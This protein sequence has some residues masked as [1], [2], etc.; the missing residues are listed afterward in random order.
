MRAAPATAFTEARL[1]RPVYCVIEHEHRDRAVAESVRAGRFRYFGQTLDLG[2]EPDWTGA[3]LPAD[4]EWRIA[5]SKFYDGLDLAH[6]FAESRDRSFLQTWERLVAS[7]IRQ[8][9]VGWDSSDVAARRVQN[10]IYAW[11]RFAAAPGFP[12]LAPGLADEI[13]RSVT[14]QAVFVR[15]N[16][17]P[18]RNHRTFELYTLFLVALALPA[19]DPGGARLAEAIRLLHENLLA[20]VL[21]D[22]V[23][24][25]C[26]THYHLLALRSFLGASENARRFA[27][28]LPD[29]FDARLERACAF[30]LHCHRPDGEIPALSDSDAGS[31]R[32]VL[33]LAG[34]LLER[35]EL[36]YAA[37]A[38]AQG[39][40]PCHRYASFPAGG[41]FFQRS[42]WGTDGAA[43]DD[44]RF[45]VFDCGPLGDGG[46]GHY[47]LLAIEA[48][49][50][51]R[52]L[53]VDPGRY[54]YAESSPNWRHWFKSTA[55][56]NTV[57]V[58]GLDQ[59]PYRRRKPKGPIARG[60]FRGR[61]TAPGLDLLC[62]EATSPCYDAVHT[63][64]VAFV[65]DEYWL[66]EDR[67]RAE[68]PHRYDL[69]FH[70]A[71]EAYSATEIARDGRTTTVRA[72][73]LAL[74]VVSSDVAVP[75]LEEGWF[76]PEYGRK[77]PAPVVSVAV[78]GATSA[79]FLTLVAPVEASGRVP[80]LRVRTAEEAAVV[81]VAGFGH[82]DVVTWTRTRAAWW[83]TSEAGDPLA[84]RLCG[85]DE[86]WVA[87]D[88]D[89]SFRRG[90]EVP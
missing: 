46:H 88:R 18:A 81:E 8:V 15:S 27:L 43:F 57:C 22:G 62:G 20:D 41:Y 31:Y 24:C 12:G 37:T 47:D 64:R 42:G 21:P 28:R 52:P 35:P 80:S 16:L 87:W 44:E 45:L 34:S 60:R 13:V 68:E 10:W 51:G 11:Q 71:A 7:W 67:L 89:G 59:T 33:V 40:P 25:E 30:A 54:T 79:T 50:G 65:S 74:V 4:E 86:D 48:A 19:T 85:A 61:L 56:H 23:H 32:E 55:A 58:D 1:P 83:R 6:A 84:F 70:L 38:G 9:P 63:R 82:R 39:I 29:G 72:P 90:S 17:T 5:W 76:A 3:A 49:A 14:E 36:L 69:R 78:E 77:V 73:G 53:L 2:T 75:A 26:S 66:V